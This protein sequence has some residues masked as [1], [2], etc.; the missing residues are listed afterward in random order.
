MMFRNVVSL[1]NAFRQP[2]VPDTFLNQSP[3]SRIGNCGTRVI[4]QG[5]KDLPIAFFY[6]ST[7]DSFAEGIAGGNC[8][9]VLLPI[10]FNAA[11][12]S[13]IV[14]RVRL[15]KDWFGD[16]NFVVKRKQP[17]C[18]RRRRVNRC[19]SLGEF[20]SR[21]NSYVFNERA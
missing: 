16:F 8:Q 12:K 18:F 6:Q 19:K 9:E 10:D 21:R 13:F 17:D 7:T 20:G 2:V 4:G 5:T 14:Q 11:A 1:G 15:G 3:V